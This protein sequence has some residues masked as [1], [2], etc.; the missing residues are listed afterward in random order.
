MYNKPL[1]TLQSAWKYSNMT[2][3][4]FA[5][6]ISISTFIFTISITH[7]LLPNK[8]VTTKS[9]RLMSQL[10]PSMS[11]VV[12]NSS[13]LTAMVLLAV[14]GANE[15]LLLDLISSTALMNHGATN[16]SEGHTMA[17][18]L[19]LCMA[20]PLFSDKSFTTKIVVQV[21]S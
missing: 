1:V 9:I 10:Q 15:I 20:M 16:W 13:H 8:S 19:C 21:P 17:T 12:T 2:I 3:L 14:S 11:T 6:N 4:G 5:H 7:V 18:T